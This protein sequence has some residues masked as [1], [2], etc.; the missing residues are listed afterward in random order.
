MSLGSRQ[1]AS[2][3]ASDATRRQPVQRQ[4]NANLRQRRRTLFCDRDSPITDALRRPPSPPPLLSPSS[5]VAATA[6]THAKQQRRQR[7]QRRRP[8]QQANRKKNNMRS[9]RCH[10]LRRS[11]RRDAAFNPKTNTTSSALQRSGR[12]RC[13]GRCRFSSVW[14]IEQKNFQEKNTILTVLF[15]SA[16]CF[17]KIKISKRKLIVQ[18]KS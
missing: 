9:A 2:R 7:R 15:Y 14:R 13:R 11:G 10:R 16:V 17:C 8:L 4:P 3:R 6:C 5:I 12:R 1:H 18:T